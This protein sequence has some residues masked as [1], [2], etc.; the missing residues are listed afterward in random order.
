MGQGRHV[1][2]AS[3]AAARVVDGGRAWGVIEL[4]KRDM[5]RKCAYFGFSRVWWAE[6]GWGW[7]KR[8]RKEVVKHRE[9]QRARRPRRSLCF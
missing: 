9:S 5:G 4:G 7:R 6:D 8:A 1:E 3:L 2:A